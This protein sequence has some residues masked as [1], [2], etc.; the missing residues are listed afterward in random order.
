MIEWLATVLP[1][2]RP[3]MRKIWREMNEQIANYVRGK[4]IEI[5][6]VALASCIAFSLLGLNYAL[7]LGIAVGLSVVIPYIGAAVV[8]LPVALIGFLQWGWGSEFFYVMLAYTII[9]AIDGNILVPL[10]FSE[11]VKMHPVVIV[12]AVLVFGGVW[13]FWGVFLLSLWH[14]CV[15]RLSRRGRQIEILFLKMTW[16][17]IALGEKHSHWL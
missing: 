6:I 11:A 12:L 3:V 16:R 7:L 14:P 17:H 9:Q 4:V 13:G 5:G 8:T 2:E 1:Q 10:L 15:K